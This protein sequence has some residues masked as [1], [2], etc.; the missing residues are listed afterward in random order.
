MRLEHYPID[1]LKSEL[2]TIIGRHLDLAQYQ[3]FF[4]GSR[5]TGRGDERS[6]IDIGI[7]GP[8]KI[9]LSM[10]GQIQEEIGALRILY[11][12]EVVDFQSVSSEFKAVAFKDREII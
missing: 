8:E 7:A 1:K 12:I 9:P 6:D 5:V 2:K 10:M 11:K 3:I 4:F